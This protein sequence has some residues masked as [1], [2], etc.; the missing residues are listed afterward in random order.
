M[1]KLIIL[2]FII[3]VSGCSR[4]FVSYHGHKYKT[5]VAGDQRWF[6][7]N[8]QTDKYRSGKKISTVRDTRS[9][10]D[11]DIPAC[12]FYKNDSI[13]LTKY[14]MIYNW[15]A[16]ND[17]Q[18]CPRKWY[19][20]A[21]AAWD[22]LELYLG[23]TSIAGGKMKSKSGWKGGHVSGDDIGFNGIA[24]GYRLEGD[25][26]E[27]SAVVWWSSTKV[28]DKDLNSLIKD[29]GDSLADKDQVWI[30][31]R[32]LES[33]SSRLWTTLNRANNGFYVRCVRKK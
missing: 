19:V 9:W 7:E 2:I 26:Q 5:I 20:P 31:G 15:L 3:I 1:K 18:L 29:T 27:G 6:A 25:Y 24:G 10:P 23:G 22:S 30:W 11:L 32:R 17:G 4:V 14:G 21:D 28:T 13:R 8:L 33:S 12:G 16:V